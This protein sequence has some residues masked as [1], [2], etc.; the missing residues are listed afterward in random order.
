MSEG[1]HPQSRCETVYSLRD[2]VLIT[3]R[4]NGNPLCQGCEG[5][6]LLSRCRWS[7]R[8]IVHRSLQA[9]CTPRSQLGQNGIFHMTESGFEL[10]HF[11]ISSLRGF[12]KCHRRR[13]SVPLRNFAAIAAPVRTPSRGLSQNGERKS[14][15]CA[16]TVT[17]Q[18]TENSTVRAGARNARPPRPA[19]A[20]PP[21]APRANGL[22][23]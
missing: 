5:E 2:E 8:A 16:H 7:V 20:R 4:G 21:P 10:S 13:W 14:V 11:V 19:P 12:Q 9:G 17:S 18:T 15:T 1:R 23:N 3:T 6:P 22:V